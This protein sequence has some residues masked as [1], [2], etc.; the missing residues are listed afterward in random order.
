MTTVI[1][2]FDYSDECAICFYPIITDK[3][4]TDCSHTFHHTCIHEWSL[5]I[6][7][8]P[9]CKLTINIPDSNLEI[10]TDEEL[11]IAEIINSGLVSDLEYQKYQKRIKQE[12]EIMSHN[13]ALIHEPRSNVN[14][15]V[16]INDYGN[17]IQD[18]SM[19]DLLRMRVLIFCE[20]INAFVM[21]WYSEYIF[22]VS[23][24]TVA[25]VTTALHR[26]KIR[27]L[28]RFT[29]VLKLIFILYSVSVEQ[30]YNHYA[31]YYFWLTW[32]TW[33]ALTFIK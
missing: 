33:F 31:F 11:R 17:D 21:I 4:V 13:V 27:V 9:F 22:Q 25:F 1:D 14:S 26:G 28:K 12:R 7:T 18:M 23:I 30:M 16:I 29:L 8:C 3:Y 19:R 2:I 5:Y 15:A 24:V 32:L 10:T 6:P 20:A